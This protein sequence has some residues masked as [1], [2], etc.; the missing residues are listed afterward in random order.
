MEQKFRMVQ[1]VGILRKMLKFQLI[2]IMI[3]LFIFNALLMYIPP[4]LLILFSPK[5]STLRNLFS[6]SASKRII[7]PLSSTLFLLK[8]SS[9]KH[10]LAFN[11]SA[12]RHISIYLIFDTQLVVGKLGIAYSIDDYIFASL[13]LYLDILNIFLYVLTLLSNKQFKCSKSKN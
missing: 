4:R 5:S 11:P 1:R 6:S 10:L 7:N 2:F 9:T 8:F 12:I 3:E 13:N